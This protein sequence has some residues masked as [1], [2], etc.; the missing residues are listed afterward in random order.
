MISIRQPAVAGQF[1]PSSPELLSEAVESYLLE[2]ER[3]RHAKQTA[4]KTAGKIPDSPH[5][6]A[7]HF[8]KA[9]IV[10]HAGYAYSGPVAATAYCRLRAFAYKI[11]R[12]VLLGPAHRVYFEGIAAPTVAG[13][14]TPLGVVELDQTAIQSLA[15]IPGVLISDEPHREEHSLEVQ[16]PFLQMLLT[17]F[18]LV[19]LVVGDVSPEVVASVLERFW[20]DDDTL[21]VVSSDLSHYLGYQQAKRV[22]EHTSLAITHLQPDAIEDSMACGCIPVK[23]LLA[24]A[25]RKGL[26]AELLDYRNSGDTAGSRDRVVGYGAYLIH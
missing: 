16:L 3:E 20:G 7:T 14:E 22:D 26:T 23:G 6:S 18:L 1:Y 21:I 10:P 15:G 13:F 17:D 5:R 25:K 19:P 24:V 11:R 2:A 12:V 4:M 9:L 8:P